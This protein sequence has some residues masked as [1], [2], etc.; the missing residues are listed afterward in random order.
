MTR[1]YSSGPEELADLPQR[2]DLT[3]HARLR[4]P[5]PQNRTFIFY[6]V[7]EI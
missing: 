3:F 7:T 5:L 1:S 4:E 6:M 2:G